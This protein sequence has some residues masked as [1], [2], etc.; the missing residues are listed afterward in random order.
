LEEITATADR[1][2]NLAE[3]LK[4]TLLNYATDDTNVGSTKPSKKEEN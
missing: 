1:L 2:G 3:D 4:D